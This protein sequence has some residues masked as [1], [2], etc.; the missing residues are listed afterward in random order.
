MAGVAGLLCSAK[1]CL[2]AVYK[3]VEIVVL[4]ARKQNMMVQPVELF[5]FGGTLCLERREQPCIGSVTTAC[6]D[7]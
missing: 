3:T 4:L 5:V 2:F 7:L 1:D 6:R